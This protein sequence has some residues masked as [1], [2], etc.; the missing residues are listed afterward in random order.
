MT[1]EGTFE[2]VDGSVNDLVDDAYRAKH[3]DSPCLEPVIGAARVPQPR[4]SF[5][6][7]PM[8]GHRAPSVGPLGEARLP[9]RTPHR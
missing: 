7:E 5:R 3:E 9:P 8:A 2:A 6:A 1:R 4:K